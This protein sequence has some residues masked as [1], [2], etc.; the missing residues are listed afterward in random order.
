[1][2]NKK[3]FNFFS[4]QEY[5]VARGKRQT[6][7]VISAIAVILLL[8]VG[9]ILY[10]QF[11]LARIEKES[12][13]IKAQLDD[14]KN[15]D[16][17]AAIHL[18]QTQIAGLAEYTSL[19]GILLE[20]VDQSRYGSSEHL[21]ALLDA[22]PATVEI[23]A[24]SVNQTAWSMDCRCNTQTDIALLLHQLEV[25][26]VFG[27]VSIG[28]LDIDEQGLISFPVQFQLEGGTVHAPQ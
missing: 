19:A 20:R 17:L 4:G 23:S 5:E 2:L 13:A 14:Q 15:R 16:Q 3:A 18:M 28:T 27:N 21:A 22:V 1:M 11:N 24:I 7:L 25:S 8:A 26:T 9:F 6:I 12:Q 10:G